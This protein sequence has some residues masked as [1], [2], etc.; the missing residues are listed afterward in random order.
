MLGGGTGFIGSRLRA[1]LKFEDYDIKVISRIGT[2]EKHIITWCD[3]ARNGLPENTVC[4]INMT[5]EKIMNPLKIFNQKFKEE[6]WVSRVGT[7]A[8]LTDIIN[9]SE[10]KPNVFINVT[11]TDIYPKDVISSEFCPCVKVPNNFFSALWYDCEKAGSQVSTEVRHVIIRSGT[12][13]DKNGG[14]VGNSY[15]PFYLGLGATIGDGCQH[16]PWIHMDDLCGIIMR[17]MKCASIC[18]VLNAVSPGIITNRQLSE[19][20]ANTLNRNV[21]FRVS[22]GLLGL[23]LGIER[24]TCLLED[25]Q[26]LPERARQIGCEFY[27]CDINEAMKNILR[28]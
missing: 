28:C 21:K 6:I 18:G 11:S 13:L 23:L 15:I 16:H 24:T 5:G 22:Q 20:L 8:F 10:Y 27:F 7:T 26:V 19:S 25:R 17:S 3:L 2:G 12:V 4:V 9:R 14:Y 1:L